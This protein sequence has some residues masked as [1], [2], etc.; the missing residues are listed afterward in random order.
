[1]RLK[2]LIA[3]YLIYYYVNRL[4]PSFSHMLTHLYIAVSLERRSCH[5]FP[6]NELNQ[7]PL[8][9]SLS[10]KRWSAFPIWIYFEFG[11]RFFYTRDGYVTFVTNY[12]FVFNYYFLIFFYW[13]L[14]FTNI[15]KM[16]L[17]Y[18]CFLFSWNLLNQL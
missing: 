4:R 11:I 17:L 2:L 5:L 9:R 18:V 15:I 8:A 1:M 13:F 7:Q 6:A 16:W 12:R 3:P 14:V 10:I